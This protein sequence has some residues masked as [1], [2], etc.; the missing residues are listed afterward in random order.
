M[1]SVPGSVISIAGDEIT[2]DAE[3][4]AS[5]LGLSAALLQA[6]MRKGIV[7][8]V[9]ETGIDEDVARTRVTFRYRTRAWTV[10]VDPA[11]NLVESVAR[12][13]GFAGEHRSLG[14]ERFRQT[15]SMTATAWDSAAKTTV[16]DNTGETLARQLRAHLQALAPL[17]LPITYREAAK[18]LLLCNYPPPLRR[19]V[20]AD[21]RWHGPER[22]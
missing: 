9:A 4:L 14:S 17:R 18:G 5:R 13:Q 12:A 2:V 8:S 10:V 21:S 15:R 16:E 19:G 3:L 20:I 22:S 6:E 11:G 7:S 1:I